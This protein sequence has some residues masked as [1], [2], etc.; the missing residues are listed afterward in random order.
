MNAVITGL[1]IDIFRLK[2]LR[3][4]LR[5]ECL[6]MTRRGQSA[7]KIIKAELGLKGSKQEVL[8]QLNQMLLSA[9]QLRS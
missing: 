6:G 4:A 8:N 5:L 1:N 2:V 3:G 7:Y 9:Q